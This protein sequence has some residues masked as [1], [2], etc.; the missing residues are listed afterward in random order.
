MCVVS[1]DCSIVSTVQY[2]ADNQTKQC[3]SICPPLTPL[4][5]NWADMNKKL[6]V[7]KCPYNKFGDN[8]TLK[9]VD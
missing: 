5:V 1:T 7:A 2:V 4:F 3:I 8:N 6:C 9:C